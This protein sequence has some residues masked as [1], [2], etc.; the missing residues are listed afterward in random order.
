MLRERDDVARCLSWGM[1]CWLWVVQARGWRGLENGKRNGDTSVTRVWQGGQ[2]WT[3][4]CEAEKVPR[5][6]ARFA[7]EMGH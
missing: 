6:D 5:S 7:E 3:L 1:W 2:L 4:T